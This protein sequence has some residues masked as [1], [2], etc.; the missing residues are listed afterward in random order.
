MLNLLVEF[1]KETSE[2]ALGLLV[3]GVI[4]L[5][6]LILLIILAHLNLFALR[7]LIPFIIIVS[8]NKTTEIPAVGSCVALSRHIIRSVTVIV[9]V[10]SPH[11]ELQIS[12]R[13]PL[14]T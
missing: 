7:P 5:K 3:L 11:D 14:V 10:N 2:Q 8:V 9:I 6:P 12:G 1:L 13:R 4:I